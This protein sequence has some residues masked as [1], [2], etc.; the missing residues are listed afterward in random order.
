MAVSDV[1]RAAGQKEGV[2]FDP[3]DVQIAGQKYTI[4]KPPTKLQFMR[5]MGALDEMKIGEALDMF[6]RLFKRTLSE[7]DYEDLTDRILDG[8]VDLED[9]VGDME[10][11]TDDSS[12]LAILTNALDPEHPTSKSVESSAASSARTGKRSTGRSPGKGSTRST[13]RSADS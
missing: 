11:E 9:L 13:S 6:D 8:E 1:A 4:V 12:Y 2:A 5:L 10:D 7:A 3:V